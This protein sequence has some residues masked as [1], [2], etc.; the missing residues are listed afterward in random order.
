[1]KEEEKGRKERESRRGEGRVR[2]G[3]ETGKGRWKKEEEE[4]GRD[5]YQRD[6]DRIVHSGECRKLKY[7]TQVNV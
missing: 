3:E 1:M 2:C 7:K 4:D 5:V 6:R